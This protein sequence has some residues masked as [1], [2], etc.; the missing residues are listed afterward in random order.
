MLAVSSADAAVVLIESP[1][2]N[3]PAHGAM[4]YEPQPMLSTSRFDGS[5]TS[6][7]NGTSPTVI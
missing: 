2:R 3:R 7:S 6:A 4:G 1:P 5:G